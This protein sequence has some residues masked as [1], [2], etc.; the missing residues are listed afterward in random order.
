LNL[1]LDMS[2]KL[3]QKLSFQM[4]QSLKL[5]QVNTLQ[6]E[7]LLK[8]ELEMNPVLEAGEEMEQE[9]QPDDKNSDKDTADE[10]N[11]LEVN[12]DKVDWEEYL[13]DGFGAG[14]SNS[15]EMETGKEYY[16]PSPVYQPTLEEHLETQLSEKKLDE[17]RRLL[18]DFL[19]NSLDSDGYLRV[20]VDEIAKVAGTGVAQVEE[21]LQILWKMEPAGVGAR[22][23]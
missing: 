16:E 20:P 6:L 19:I 12:E 5:L 18:V 22:N 13:E 1:G 10:D 4:I 9:E 11:E 3:Q 21:A 15:D 8:T 17:N 14:G 7:Q 23:L 2:L